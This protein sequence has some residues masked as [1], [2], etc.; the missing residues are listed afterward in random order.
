MQSNFPMQP[1][2][3]PE[4]LGSGP[5]LL[6]LSLL[7]LGNCVAWA[8]LST[9]LAQE[10]AWGCQGATVPCGHSCSRRRTDAPS[11]CS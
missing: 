9:W 4:L 10:E 2:F 1:E 11:S 5:M 8:M 6:T 3:E 7:P